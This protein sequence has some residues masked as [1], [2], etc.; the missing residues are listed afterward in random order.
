MLKRFNHIPIIV[1]TG[2]CLALFSSK[3]HGDQRW[4]TARTVDNKTVPLSVGVPETN[5]N[6]PALAVT[7]KGSATPDNR[8]IDVVISLWNSPAGDNNGNTQGNPGSEE[9]DNIEKIIQHFANGVYEMTEGGH[10][11]RNVRIYRNNSRPDADVMWVEMEHP[12]VPAG[13]GVLMPNGHIVTCDTFTNGKNMGGG[14]YQNKNM[15]ADEE[16]AGYTLAHEWGHYF[17][18]VYDEYT[19]ARVGRGNPPGRAV[20]RAIM[21]SQWHAENG[22]YDWLNL[23]VRWRGGTQSTSFGRSEDTKQTVQH[24][25]FGE[26]AW[27]TVARRP[28]PLESSRWAYVLRNP[29]PLNGASRQTIG[30]RVYYPE[31]ASASVAPQGN[32]EPVNQLA[33]PAGRVAATNDLNIIWMGTNVVIQIVID[34]SGSM[35]TENNMQKAMEAAKNLVEAVNLDTALG[36]IDFDDV[37]TELYPITKI[38]NAAN[39]TAIKNAIDTLYARNMTSIGEASRSALTGLLAYNISKT[40][41]AVF[42]LSDG[43]SNTGEDPLAVIPAYQA[44]Q[45]PIFGFGYG[46]SVDPRLEQMAVQTGGKYYNSPTTLADVQRAFTDANAIVQAR[47][48]VSSGQIASSSAPA[49]VDTPIVVDSTMTQLRL[50]AT[51]TAGSGGTT[52]SLVD[53]SGNV[54]APV[55]SQQVGQETLLS[56]S[57]ENP[58]VGTWYLR[59]TLASNARLVYQADSSVSGFSFNLSAVSADGDTVTSG[60]PIHIVANVKQIQSVKLAAVTAVVTD[61]NGSVSTLVLSNAASGMYFG[62][63]TATGVE[64]QYQVEVYA[65]N[66]GGNA[67]FTY[68]DAIFSQPEGGGAIV[69]PPDA[70]VG[71]NFARVTSFAVQV[72]G[73][74]G[75]IVLD[76]TADV[77]TTFNSWT[78]DRASGA[79]IANI[80]LRND[81]GKGGLPLE[82][83]F[84]YAITET[85]N[86]RLA[87]VSGHTSGLAFLDVTS[88]VEAQLPAIGNGDLRLDPGEAVSFTVAFYSRDLSIPTGH[89]FGIW[90]DPP[91]PRGTPRLTPSGVR[92]E[93]NGHTRLRV[94]GDAGV[95]CIIEASSDLV[96]WIPI[97]IVTN[98]ASSVEFTDRETAKQACRYYRVR[99]Q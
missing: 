54:L 1:I 9:Q 59:G 92:R 91:S 36:V 86:F 17:Y 12:H 95:G 10:R 30:A 39:R 15:L 29:F 90:A 87:T 7:A 98:T 32:N 23:S 16:G 3:L 27:E 31:L 89:V 4:F 68:D 5:S 49:N 19:D 96:H 76:V 97:G 74:G 38:T 80:S 81:S 26:S 33:T 37:V 58:A 72:K 82:K 83:T 24:D 45:V 85:T 67:M 88:Q 78:L 13:G 35:G 57:V 48:Q 18:G 75:N 14:I 84:W 93:A 79:L 40:T 62:D 66:N 55:S 28:G 65:N 52:L 61:P 51:Y 21:N 11:L 69:V 43:Y 53:P 63:Y 2:L 8:L 20:D 46:S 56:F 77:T 41:A 60:Q 99:L 71:T 94:T 50:T 70:P 47:A 25:V 6:A 73:G 22:Q 44:A 42:L 34:R 64:G